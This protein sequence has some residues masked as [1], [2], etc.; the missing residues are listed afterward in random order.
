M[1]PSLRTAHTPDRLTSLLRALAMLLLIV[2]SAA[3]SAQ[4]RDTPVMLVL[5]DSLSASHGIAVEDG[6]VSL[7]EQRLESSGNPHVLINASIG[8]E[9]TRGGLTRLPAML[10]RH[11]PDWV[12]ISL[13]GA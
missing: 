6:W 9:T 2:F 12:I 4:A 7:L 10:E 1:M 3:G 13:G 8:G 5:G 11:Q